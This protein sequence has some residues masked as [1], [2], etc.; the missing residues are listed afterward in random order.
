MTNLRLLSMDERRALAEE[1]A[2]RARAG[3]APGAIRAAL[4]VSLGT[5]AR[6]AKQG[7]FRQAD[8]FPKAAHAGA[9]TK[10]KPGP[11]GYARSGRYYRGE[12]P[13]EDSAVR[14]HGAGHPGWMGG[15]AASRERYG[16]LRDARRDAYGLEVAGLSPKELLDRVE[17]ALAEGWLSEVDRLMRA[18]RAQARRMA[19]LS[20]LKEEAKPKRKL[21]QDMDDEELATYFEKLM[22]TATATGG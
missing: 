8:L 22:A 4:G 14:L 3:E 18:W 5:Y 7:G 6:W 21:I 9:P 13:P 11:G 17:D 2:R 19:S 1:A 10:H 16:A 15:K 20:V 12:G